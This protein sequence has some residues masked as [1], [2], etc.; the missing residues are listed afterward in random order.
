MIPSFSNLL[1]V[2]MGTIL[3]T[4]L[5]ERY[6]KA[7]YMTLSEVTVETLMRGHYKEKQDSEGTFDPFTFY[8]SV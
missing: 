3:V 6:I 7:I 1:L 4:L 2:K 8:K 5:L